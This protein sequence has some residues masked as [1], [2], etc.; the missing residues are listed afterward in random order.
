[1]AAVAVVH[2]NLAI[3]TISSGC[4]QAGLSPSA[5]E[6]ASESPFAT[7]LGDCASTLAPVLR[8]QY[9][10][11]PEAPYRPLLTGTAAHV[12]HRPA[13]LWPFFWGLGG[14]GILFP[15]TGSSVPAS[16]RIDVHR[17]ADGTVCHVWRRIF[18][19]PKPRPFDALLRFDRAV[20]RVV[21]HLGPRGALRV[22]WNV[23]VL[24]PRLMVIV[25]DG[26]SLGVGPVRL[27]LPRFLCPDV[28]AIEQ[29]DLQRDDT[30]HMDLRVRHCVLGPIFG[31][32]GTFRMQRVPLAGAPR[33]RW[34]ESD[35]DVPSKAS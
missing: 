21:E 15:D 9:L 19:F 30:I 4:A 16:L 8:A 34:S 17:D 1:M 28:R 7:A 2:N 31:Y 3:D 24:T 35:T 22:A 11:T 32:H 25:T 23:H 27:P 6:L 26:M 20:N 14:A 12:W 10:L 13:W 18:G 33:G 29:A 5:A